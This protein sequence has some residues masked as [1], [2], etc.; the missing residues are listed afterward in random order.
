VLRHTG[1]EAIGWPTLPG[2]DEK[3]AAPL[4]RAPVNSQKQSLF[5]SRAYLVT[6]MEVVEVLPAVSHALAV[7]VWVPA[8][9]F[10]V[11]PIFETTTPRRCNLI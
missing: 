10:G 7:M 11:V 2:R 1:T 9:T 8:L 4:T 3:G 6:V 5:S